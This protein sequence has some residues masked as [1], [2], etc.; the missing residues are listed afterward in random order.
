MECGKIGSQKAVDNVNNPSL[1][2]WVRED[3]SV[4]TVKISKPTEEGERN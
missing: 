3:G 4:T 1:Q 2:Y